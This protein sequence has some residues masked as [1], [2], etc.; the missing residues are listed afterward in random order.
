MASILRRVKYWAE[1]ETQHSFKTEKP[2]T[3]FKSIRNQKIFKQKSC[4]QNFSE[5]LK[6]QQLK[7][8]F[9]MKTKKT[10]SIYMIELNDVIPTASVY[11]SKRP[12]EKK[13]AQQSIIMKRPFE[14]RR[15]MTPLLFTNKANK[16]D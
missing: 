11:H 2:T 10:L 3:T 6:W 5:L 4:R 15:N 8:Q 7:I 9:I 16:I 14:E 1:L 13:Y 12:S